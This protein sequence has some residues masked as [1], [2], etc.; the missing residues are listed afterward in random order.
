[1][2]VVEKR[3]PACGRLEVNITAVVGERTRGF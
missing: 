3:T 1:M 2:T